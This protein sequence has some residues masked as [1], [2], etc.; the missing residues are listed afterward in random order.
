[1]GA[2]TSAS[3]S[4]ASEAGSGS[5]GGVSRA[6]SS[7]AEASAPA[8]NN[9]RIA[10][11]SSS[12]PWL[13]LDS[14]PSSFSRR[15]ASLSSP[16]AL[17]SASLASRN[18]CAA[19]S[20]PRLLSS[21]AAS[22]TAS[23][24]ERS[25]FVLSPW[26]IVAS[27]ELMS[28]PI[29]SFSWLT[30]ITSK[31]PLVLGGLD[32]AFGSAVMRDSTSTNFFSAALRRLTVPATSPSGKVPSASGLTMSFRAPSSTPFFARASF[33]SASASIWAVC[34]SPTAPLA[35]LKEAAAA[36]RAT[37]LALPSSSRAARASF[38]VLASSSQA[39]FLPVPPSTTPC[40][41]VTA[42]FRATSVATKASHTISTTPSW[43]A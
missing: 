23:A 5:G 10:W 15:S 8:W 32:K 19:A 28:F 40:A 16:L 4:G 38:L 14:G 35:C 20:C 2:P 13:R 6:L 22:A 25:L 39:T 9:S 12:A 7:C 1:M 3:A 17:S 31:A 11:A 30:T 18:A 34:A 41:S 27:S 42:C 21:R 26:L 37:F 33:R 24:A 43:C 36:A 29:S